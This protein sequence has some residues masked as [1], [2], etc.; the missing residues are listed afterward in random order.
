M[1]GF[2]PDGLHA[3]FCD[4]MTSFERMLDERFGPSIWN[5]ERIAFIDRC[6][7]VARD[8][9]YMSEYYE[10]MNPK[11]LTNL[12]KRLAEGMGRADAK[13]EADIIWGILGEKE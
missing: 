6:N 10:A 9:Q 1:I 5:P 11:S 8:S 12:S 4:A 13:H 7:I 3:Q 2:N